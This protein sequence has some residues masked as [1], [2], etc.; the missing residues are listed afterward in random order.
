VCSTKNKRDLIHIIA[1]L[2]VSI[3]K[4]DRSEIRI[5]VLCRIIKDKLIANE[6]K[7]RGRDSNYKYLYSWWDENIDLGARL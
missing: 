3:S 6:I 5:K 2:G 7:E 4:M 1:S